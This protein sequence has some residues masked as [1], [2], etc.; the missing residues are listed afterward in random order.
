MSRPFASR[1]GVRRRTRGETV[2]DGVLWAVLSGPVLLGDLLGRSVPL[3]WWRTT[4]GLLLLAAAVGLSRRRPVPGLLLIAGLSLAASPGLLTVS[5]TPALSALGYL[6]GRREAT[7]RPALLAFTA[8]AATGT[9]RTLGAPDPVI[10]WLV[11][12]ATLLF[13]AVFPWL[14]GRHR[15]QDRAL[16]AAGWSRAA[17]LEREQRI[18]ADRARLRERAR[19]AQDM[20]DSLGHDLSLIALRAGALQVAPGLDDAHRAAARELRVAAAEATERLREIIGVLRDATAVDAADAGGTDATAAGLAAGGLPDAGTGAPG[21]ASGTAPLVPAGESIEALVERA[22]DSGLP[23]RL[24]RTAA[25]AD[26]DRASG[27]DGRAASRTFGERGREPGPGRDD[28]TGRTE[29][30]GGTGR[31]GIPEDT[32][33]TGRTG[34]VEDT[35]RTGTTG[36]TGRTRLAPMTERAAY[37]V[38]QESLTNAAKHAPGAH[39]TVTIG[40]RTA[41][42]SRGAPETETVVRV[43]T[44]GG[45]ARPDPAAPPHSRGGTGLVGLRERV[46]LVGGAFS[47]GPRDG[48]FEV[49]A[50]LPHASADGHRPA[51]PTASGGT[52]PEA[53]G[54]GRGPGAGGT[55]PDAPAPGAIGGGAGAAL[56]DVPTGE[57]AGGGAVREFARARRAT[58]RGLVRSLTVGGGLAALV[59]GAAVGWYAYSRTHCV[60]EPHDFAALRVGQTRAEVEP[61]LPDRVAPDPPRERAVAPPP[62]SRC[63]YYRASDELFVSVDHFRLCFRDGRLVAKDVVPGSRVPRPVEGPQRT[64]TRRGDPRPETGRHHDA[65]GERREWTR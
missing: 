4:G 50:R 6:A 61:V 12:I 14:V 8:I 54:A 30:P 49:V 45:A 15:R 56:W 18:I 9:V 53:P 39:V 13:G 60:L 58:R 51:P 46:A 48:G 20:H 27:T 26:G 36:G 28:R 10:V 2:R 64:E 40:E 63:D 47:A 43:V 41:T 59:V 33:G 32:G 34:A 37:R 21:S 22:A 55:R 38:V 25:V 24:V 16:V 31:T 5:Y 7:A 23:V 1:P 57:G 17:Q 62:G 44:S 35:G 3:P 11:L 65:G 52:R 19:I 42:G 29:A